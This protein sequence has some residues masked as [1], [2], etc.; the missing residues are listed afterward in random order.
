MNTAGEVFGDISADI[1]VVRKFEQ[2]DGVRFVVTREAE[3]EGEAAE[4][5]QAAETM[6]ADAAQEDP[7]ETVAEATAEEGSAEEP[8]PLAGEGW[9]GGSDVKLRSVAAS[10]PPLTPPRKGD[11]NGRVTPP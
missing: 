3:P 11:G 6:G 8:S 10:P 5:A 2:L 1:V 9:E 4:T 7:T